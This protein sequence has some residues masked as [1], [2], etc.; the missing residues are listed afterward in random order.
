MSYIQ[1]IQKIVWMNIIYVIF[2]FILLV[3]S[4]IN[5]FW[6]DEWGKFKT[7]QEKIVQNSVTFTQHKQK[8]SAIHWNNQRSDSKPDSTQ[9][10]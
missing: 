3:T 2:Y 10:E 1:A 9:T 6:E 8:T 5:V 4:R 7:N